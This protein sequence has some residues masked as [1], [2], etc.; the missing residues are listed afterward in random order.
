MAKLTFV[1]KMTSAYDSPADLLKMSFSQVRNPSRP[2]M[3]F[4]L[5][6]KTDAAQTETLY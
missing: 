3:V 5:V 2:P 1:P 6:C 4:S